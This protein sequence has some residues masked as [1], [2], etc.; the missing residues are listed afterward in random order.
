MVREACGVPRAGRAFPARGSER[1]A[2]VPC[3]NAQEGGLLSQG[4][5]SLGLEDTGRAGDAANTVWAALLPRKFLSRGRAARLRCPAHT[6][7]RPHARHPG[8][9]GSGSPSR[10]NGPAASIPAG[11]RDAPEPLCQLGRACLPSPHIL[12]LGSALPDLPGGRV[13]AIISIVQGSRKAPKSEFITK[14][15]ASADSPPHCPSPTLPVG[16]DRLLQ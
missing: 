13:T 7:L 6:D 10:S 2:P 11:L 16:W 12:A 8:T 4:T 15:P 5:A 14:E 1:P 3:S 9:Q